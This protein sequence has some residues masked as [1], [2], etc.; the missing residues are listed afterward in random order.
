MGTQVDYIQNELKNGDYDI[1]EIPYGTTVSANVAKTYGYTD[2]FGK[3]KKSKKS[4]DDETDESDKKGLKEAFE[5]PHSRCMLY[6]ASGFDI[7]CILP[8]KIVQ[9][10][11]NLS[12]RLM[13]TKQILDKQDRVY[14]KAKQAFVCPPDMYPRAEINQLLS[15]DPII[16]GHETH[17]ILF[18]DISQAAIGKDEF[19]VDD[20]ELH[21]ERWITVREPNGELRLAR[22]DERDIGLGVFYMDQRE[23]FDINRKIR[24]TP[25]S[26][27]WNDRSFEDGLKH[28]H[29]R[30]LLERALV[31]FDIDSK[32]WLLLRNRVFLDLIKSRKISEISSTRFYPLFIHW[33]QT[34]QD[35]I[36]ADLYKVAICLLVMGKNDTSQTLA[37]IDEMKSVINILVEL[38]RFKLV[39]AFQ[40]NTAEMDNSLTQIET[41]IRKSKIN[42]EGKFENDAPGIIKDSALE[43]ALDDELYKNLDLE[44]NDSVYRPILKHIALDAGRMFGNEMLNVVNLFKE[45]VGHVTPNENVIV[46]RKKQ[47]GFQPNQQ[48]QQNQNN[49]RNRR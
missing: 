44:L 3:K 45:T 28:G 32:E 2:Y 12:L 7:E 39:K 29:H 8:R 26:L 42:S 36:S 1:S 22:W 46:K 31:Q 41:Q 14:Q 15:K 43:F 37:G 34:S 27:M 35:E 25:P 16:N 6:R 21:R 9:R 13:T 4:S 40:M 17:D 10:K 30:Q 5:D 33:L 47:V 20:E 48:N 11:K 18:V 24:P 19:S 38:N 49:R 23:E